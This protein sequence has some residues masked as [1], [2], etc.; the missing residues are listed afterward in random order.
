MV[1]RL[2]LRRVRKFT[3]ILFGVYNL[4]PEYS[5]GGN[6][7]NLDL[8]RFGP[9]LR[10]MLYEALDFGLV[11]KPFQV[12]TWEKPTHRPSM[13]PIWRMLEVLPIRHLSYHRDK[14]DQARTW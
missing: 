13:T 10:W 3:F 2:S 14:P 4:T 1:R 5:G 6:A 12:Y 7:L 8:S 11:V 9:A